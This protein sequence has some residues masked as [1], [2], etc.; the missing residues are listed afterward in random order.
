MWVYD[1]FSLSLSHCLT[2]IHRKYQILPGMSWSEKYVGGSSMF[3]TQSSSRFQDVSGNSEGFQVN[4]L[5]DD[6]EQFF[7]FSPDSVSP[8]FCEQVIEKTNSQR[9]YVF[10]CSWFECNCHSP[11]ATG[12]K[13]KTANKEKSQTPNRQTSLSGSF[14][15]NCNS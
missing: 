10:Q 4:L 11:P 9:S 7:E 8:H 3:N 6:E 5:R 14:S 13:T 12:L 15:P 1:E 2:G